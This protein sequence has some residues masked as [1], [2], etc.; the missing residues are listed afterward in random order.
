M[1][2]TPLGWALLIVVASPVAFSLLCGVLYLIAMIVGVPI[3]MIAKGRAAKGREER[4]TMVG[5]PRSR[6]VARSLP[7]THRQG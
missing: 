5:P 2:L 7:P 1:H 6:P 3:A 4:V